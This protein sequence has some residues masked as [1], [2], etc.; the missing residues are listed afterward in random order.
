MDALKQD[1]KW[2]VCGNRQ[3]WVYH[4]AY[5]RLSKALALLYA[6][7]GAG[8]SLADRSIFDFGFG[9]GTFFRYCPKQNP[10][11]GVELNDVHVANV[12]ESLRKNGYEHVD[13]R[14]IDQEQWRDHELLARR[15]DLVVASHVLEHL[16]DPVPLLARL[17]CCLTPA[18]FLLGAVPIN[19]SVAHRE[20]EWAVDRTLLETWARA[21]HAEIIDYRELDCFTYYALP[22]FAKE[23]RLGRVMAQTTSLGLGVCA[24]LFGMRRWFALSALLGKVAG[25][26]PGQA[27]FL[28]RPAGAGARAETD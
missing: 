4:L 7:G 23:S 1:T 6:L 28:M 26:K 11:F 20:H 2:R 24:A 16:K 9:A 27:V 22:I 19:E 21:A 8:L 3:S 18:G 13:L 12:K 10:L 17:V 14:T 5:M 25:A 15:Y